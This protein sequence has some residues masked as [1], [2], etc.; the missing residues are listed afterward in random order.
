MAISENA[1]E[2]LAS[3]WSLALDHAALDDDDFYLLAC[4]GAAVEGHAKA[5]NYEPGIA[6]DGD[7]L[8]SGAVLEEANAP[9]QIT[10]HRIAAF[11]DVDPDDPVA[12]A[13]LA[14][15]LRH[16]IEHAR[17]RMVCGGVLFAIDQ[18][19]DDAIGFKAGGLPG[20][21]VLYNFKPIEQDANAAAAMLL[22]DRFE[23]G[24]VSEILDSQDAALARSLVG[25]GNPESLPARTVCFI[26]LFADVV[27]EVSR[28]DNSITFDRRLDAVSK[29][30]GDLWRA[31]AGAALGSGSTSVLARP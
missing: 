6:Q 14:A 30:A 7:D 2:P 8:L 3:A 13:I 16:E 15:T 23:A 4:P 19:A 24:I 28:K 20:S 1:E 21:R 31:L 10:K 17:Q 18:Y 5:A 22:R 11:E 25:P 12:F 9:A 29:S 26:Y 27:E